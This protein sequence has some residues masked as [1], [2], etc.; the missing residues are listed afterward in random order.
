[1]KKLLLLLLLLCPLVILAQKSPCK[2]DICVVQFN[3]GWNSTNDVEW[4][5]D[6]NDCGIKYIDIAADADAAAKYEIVV[7]PTI[8]V[9]NG[10]E[11]KRFQADISFAMKATLKDVQ[12]V[13]DEILMDSF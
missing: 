8:I 12:E 4:V 13:V 5:T 3:A 9:F 1:M 10:E 2:A 11:V 6:I 7:V